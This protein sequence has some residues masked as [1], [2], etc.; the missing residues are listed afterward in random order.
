MRAIRT[1]AARIARPSTVG[2]MPNVWNAWLC[3]LAPTGTFDRP[4]LS[5]EDSFQ[6][7]CICIRDVHVLTPGRDRQIWPGRAKDGL[8]VGSGGL[9]VLVHVEQVLRVVLLLDL[10]KPLVIRLVVDLDLALVV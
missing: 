8:A 1:K 7:P 2:S 6:S 3:I 9:D 4:S 10:G 5:L